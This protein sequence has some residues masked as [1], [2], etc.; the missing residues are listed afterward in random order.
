MLAWDVVVLTGYLLLNLGLV[1]YVLYSHYL[2]EA[3]S[4]RAHFPVVPASANVL[5]TPINSFRAFPFAASSA[6]RSAGSRLSA[7]ASSPPPSS[8]ARR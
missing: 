8:R 3:A 4:P 5:A 7:R 1:G 6:A 2:A